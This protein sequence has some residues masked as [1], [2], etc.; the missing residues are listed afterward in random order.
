[1]VS[2]R[3]SPAPVQ[4]FTAFLPGLVSA[5]ISVGLIRSGFLAVF[6]LVPLGVIAGKYNT[7]TLLFSLFAAVLGNGLVSLGLA[8]SLGHNGGDLIRDIFYF[9]FTMAVYGWIMAPAGEGFSFLRI[10][11]AYRFI[12][13]AAAEALAFLLIFSLAG[14]NSAFRYILREQAETITSFYIASSGS[15]VVQRSLLEQYL[16]PELILETLRLV[17]LRGG[18][19]VSCLFIFF[20]NRQLSLFIVRLTRRGQLPASSGGM[21]RFHASPRLIWVLSFTLFFVLLSRVVKIEVLE[22][23]AWNILVICVVLYLAQGGGIVLHY[24]SRSSLPP[25]LRLMLNIAIFFLILSPGINAFALGAVALLGIAENWVPF[26][27][28]KSHGPSST[29]G[30]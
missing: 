26:R 4:D 9:T 19:V 10:S 7:K 12:A 16:T 21:A 3:D 25:F 28:P 6:F 1:M 15:D 11:R 17:I 23:A 14:D 29:P 13:G 2:P 5:V 8:Y 27:A 18:G 30:M 24:L 20:I 22:I